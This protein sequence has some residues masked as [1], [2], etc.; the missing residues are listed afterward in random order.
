MK[1]IYY[2]TQNA[3]LFVSLSYNLLPVQINIIHKLPIIYKIYVG[4]YTYQFVQ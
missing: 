1:E 2:I 3:A 4:R